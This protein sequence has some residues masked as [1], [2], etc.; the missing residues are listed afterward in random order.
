MVRGR[1]GGG[2]LMVCERR[3]LWNGVSLLVGPKHLRGW[4]EVPWDLQRGRE[5]LVVGSREA[6]SVS[7]K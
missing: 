2:C 7:E 4:G 5:L 3:S 1:D 6:V